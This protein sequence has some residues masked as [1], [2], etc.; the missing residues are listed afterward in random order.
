VAYRLKGWAGGGLRYPALFFKPVPCFS[1]EPFAKGLSSKVKDA[2]S[3]QRGI[4]R[5][6]EQKNKFW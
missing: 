5:K 6:I 3:E 4:L 1:R 2:A